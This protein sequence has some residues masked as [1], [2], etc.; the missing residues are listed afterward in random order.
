VN[1]AV[2][3]SRFQPIKAV[4]KTYLDKFIS[5]NFFRY[6]LKINAHVD[7]VAQYHINIYGSSDIDHTKN[8]FK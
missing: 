3:N 4:Y 5:F 7:M 8:G 6:P 1:G 2:K